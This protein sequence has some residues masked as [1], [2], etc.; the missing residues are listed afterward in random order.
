MAALLGR[1]FDFETLAEASGQE[2]DRLIDALEEAERAQLIE[3]L[4]GEGGG[5]FAFVHALIPATLVEGVR[6]LRRRLL[7]RRAARA[8]EARRP[9]DFEALAYHYNQAGEVAKGAEYLLQAGDRARVLYAHEEAIDHY[10]GALEFLKEAGDLE[11]AARTLMKLGLTH[12]TALQFR[13]ARQIY[14]E[15]FALWQRAGE[16]ARR[17]G[18]RPRPAPHT[19][20]LPSMPWTLDP[21]KAWDQAISDFY[22]DQLFSGLL[23][24]GPEM[25]VVPDV[26]RS[27]EISDGG[28]VYAFNLR[29]DVR[30]SDG[31]P[32]TAGD[33]EYAWKRALDPAIGSHV[34]TVLYDI[35][36]ARVFH[37]G[38]GGR[39]EVGVHARDDFTLVVE[40]ETPMSF[41]LHLMALTQTRPVPRHVVG[42]HGEAWTE[43]H[44][45]VSNGPFKLESWQRLQSIV[46]SRNPTYHGR[47]TGNVERVESI[48]PVDLSVLDPADDS[49]WATVAARALGMYETG[50]VDAI[51]LWP[52]NTDRA[53]RR[54]PDEHVTAPV[55]ATGF[56]AFDVRRPPFDDPRVRR[57]FAHATDREW[58]VDVAMGGRFFPATG[59]LVPP[60]MPGHSPGISLPYDPD[61]ARQL[62]AQ[63]GYPGGQGFPSVEAPDQEALISH[64]QP[65]W[66]RI[67]GIEITRTRGDFRGPG[68]FYDQL[69]A[70]PPRMAA[71]GGQVSTLDPDGYLRAILRFST[72]R[73]KA[74]FAL[75]EKARSVM[76]PRERMRLYAQADRIL[77][78]GAAFV[79]LTYGRVHWLVKPWVTAF[80]FSALGHFIFKDV[81]IEPH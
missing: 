68:S 39:D 29:D 32:V 62:L 70:E 79:P 30:W 4:S 69:R 59:G 3:E 12:Y 27:W 36:G 13:R 49:T 76:D 7:H 22:I 64:L 11:R 34:G 15:G 78:E 81:I 57:A 16:T 37:Q 52:Y 1:E 80:P 65:Q 17:E 56:L 55:L 6:T 21:T 63:A 71:M 47:F 74:Y 33:F 25:E 54:Y 46:L 10:Q 42:A 66:Q 31:V 60:G 35:Q 67:L 58:L 23:E 19:L 75:V 45:I 14:D 5:T 48:F 40:L 50:S 61:R 41:F 18:V 44:N 28:R 2:E 8:I 53:R 43:A 51:W 26:A 72:W 73:D 24:E 20:R 38:L 9:D 77:V